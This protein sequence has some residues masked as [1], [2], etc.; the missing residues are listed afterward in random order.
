LKPQRESQIFVGE[1]LSIHGRDFLRNFEDVGAPGQELLSDKLQ[2]ALLAVL[3]TPG[4]NC[5]DGIFLIGEEI[6]HL[7][8]QELLF[9]ILVGRKTE[10]RRA[11]FSECF[12]DVGWEWAGRGKLVL[13]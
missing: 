2:S 8:E 12:L 4:Q 11:N 10:N 5:G 9:G 7:P 3:G 13:K 1:A 6:L